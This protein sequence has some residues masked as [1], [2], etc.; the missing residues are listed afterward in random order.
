MLAASL[1]MLTGVGP[2][3]PECTLPVILSGL[4]TAQFGPFSMGTDAALATMLIVN[5]SPA[6]LSV[7]SPLTGGAENVSDAV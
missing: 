1:A 3:R 5:G 2:S 6:S 7:S 4:Y